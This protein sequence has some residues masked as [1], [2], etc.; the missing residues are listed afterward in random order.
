MIN[1]SCEPHET[2]PIKI[3]ARGGERSFLPLATERLAAFVIAC[4]IGL[5][6]FHFDDASAQEAEVI[7]GG[8]LEY[9]KYC[10]VCHGVDARGG[11]IMAKFLTIRPADLTQIATRNGGTFPFWQIYRIIDGGDVRGHG[12][13]DMPIWGDRF[14]TQ[15][16]GNDPGSRAQ[17]AGRLLGLV[18]YLQ[19]IQQ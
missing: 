15:A 14:R 4:F 12:T 7:A 5:A 2:R 19:H 13:R 6:L 3:A 17:A 9:Q 1:N 11:G 16:G 18:F 10:A 8:E